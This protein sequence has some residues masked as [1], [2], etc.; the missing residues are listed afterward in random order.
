MVIDRKIALK[1]NT[2]LKQIYN[3][4]IYVYIH[5]YIRIFRKISFKN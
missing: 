5:F 2:S 4:F 1:T 3:T